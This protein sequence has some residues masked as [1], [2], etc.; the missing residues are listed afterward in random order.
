[1]QFVRK[2]FAAVLILFSVLA[3]SYAEDFY[4]E[5]PEVITTADSRFPRSVTNG[6][7]SCVIWQ[8]TDKKGKQLWLSA[9]YYSDITKPLE[10]SKFTEPVKFSGEVPD[11][12]SAAMK[13]DGSVY[14]ALLSGPHSI[15]IYRISPD[16][17][18]TKYDLPKQSKFLTAPRLYITAKGG[19]R[20]FCSSSE[21]ESFSILTADSDTGTFWSEL[22]QFRPTVRYNNSFVPTLVPYKGG[23][24]VV[25]QAQLLT[26]S[27]ISYQLYGTYSRDGRIWSPPIIL[28]DQKTIPVSDTRV[29]TNYQN[30]SPVLYVSG[31]DCYLSWER[32][33][34]LSENAN[35]W[36]EKITP[37]G[38]VAGSVEQITQAGNA[39]RAQIFNFN[40][41]LSMVWF[42]TRSGSERVYMAQKNGLY[43]DE[44]TLSG[45]RQKS[46]FAFPVISND[47]NQL[48]FV[49]QQSAKSSGSIVMLKPD[50]SVSSPDINPLSFKIG[51][52][53][54]SRNVR[55]RV[56][57]PDDSSGVAGFSYSWSKDPEVRPSKEMEY[58]AG[59][60]TVNLVADQ[61]GDWYF[62]ARVFDYA[63]NISESSYVTY[64]L[65]I[66]APGKPELFLTATDKFGFPTAN[67]FSAQIKKNEEDTDV[68]GYTYSLD[69]IAALPKSL[70]DTPR[71]PLRLSLEQVGSIV[72]SLEEKYAGYLTGSRKV[73]SKIMS[74]KE[75]VNFTSR[76]NGIYILTVAVI[77]EVGNI[78]EKTAKLVVL[79]KFIPKTY[80]LSADSTVNELGEIT[81]D[82]TGGGF[83]Y[84]GNISSIYIDRDGEEPYD[85]ILTRDSGNYKVE[86]DNRITG[87]KLGNNLDEGMYRIGLVH[88]DRGLYMTKQIVKIEQ[89]GTIKIEPEI[90]FVPEWKVIEEKYK[91]TINTNYL[92]LAAIILLSLGILVFAFHGFVSTAR[93]TVLVRKEVAALITG[94]LMPAEKKQKT[95]A[96]KKKGVSLKIKM[97]GFTSALVI[98]IVALVAVPLGYF[99]TNMQER[100]LNRGLQQR[101]D[102][103]LESLSSGAKAYMPAN[104]ILELSYLPGQATSMSEARFATIIG[105]S[106][107]AE[108]A[109]MDYVWATNDPKINEK[110]DTET[111]NF[112]VSRN[113]EEIVQKITKDCID[114]NQKAVEAAGEIALTISELNSE[115]VSLALK[116]DELS[117][118]R[119]EEI[120]V[121]TTEL[122]GK[123][124]TLLNDIS[125]SGASSYPKFDE[126]L[127]DRENT[128]FLFYKP[129]LFRQGSSQNYVHGVILLQVSTQSLVDE[130]DLSRT[131][132]Y[133]IAGIV[134]LLA[135]LVGA[136]LSFILASI[137]IKPIKKLASYV[138]VIGE[139]KDKAKLKGKDFKVTSKDEI[140]QLGEVINNMTSQLAKAAE[141]E[142]LS[143]DGKAVQQAFLPLL[144]GRQ[145]PQTVAEHK[146]DHLECFGYYEGASGVSG[147]YFDYRKLD[148][149]WFAIIKCDASGHGVPAAL[150]MTVVATHFREYFNNWSYAKDGVKLNVLVTKINDALES[151]GLKGK[152]AAMIICLFDTKSG[153]VFMCNAGDN[154]VHIYDSVE[155]KQKILTLSETPAAGP[156]P[157]FMVDMKGGFKVEKTNLKKGDVLFLYTDG[158][159]ESTRLCRRSDFS[160][161]VDELTDQNGNLTNE[162]RKELMEPERVQGVIE[163]VFAKEKFVLNKEDNPVFGE[164]LEFDFTNCEGNL[165]EVILALASVEKVFRLYKT[166]EATVNDTITVDKRI[167]AFLKDHFNLYNYYCSNRVDIEEGNYLEYTNVAEDEQ[168][169]DLTLLAV[170]RL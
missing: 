25:F 110:I 151:L 10:I 42:D 123:L 74:S 12:Y 77:D 161:I 73:P 33:Y 156:L 129:V 116:T 21:N 165:S 163:A 154:I 160:V 124:T 141:D 166:P 119:R 145:R 147:D 51:H 84:D 112:G 89:N 7:E 20:L 28:T 134:A 64:N 133:V 100:T 49:W 15:A 136:V 113:I 102:V 122:N 61:D 150:I 142:K 76:S 78:S 82:V 27:R 32:T 55:I 6:K 53:S 1:M 79:N 90:K 111:V 148:D 95:E 52:H 126:N 66:T 14:V 158:I 96:L 60:N 114:L 143:L 162:E 149:R 54:T 153:D 41:T 11:I 107:N 36:L 108:K 63:G 115:G 101:V 22:S 3:F 121:I 8:E 24:L 2:F 38:V 118:S 125:K 23:D 86:S 144:A 135:V 98:A 59:Q 169:D 81:L 167:D 83:T 65:D 103:M 168:L 35:L 146:D 56:K 40:N 44:T 58:L 85:M 94:G 67:A 9:V 30:Q 132:V 37:E 152:F 104:N 105:E 131:T 71:R 93:E 139:T 137:I 91:Y 106:E 48:S 68:G 26:G 39:S 157:S 31:N 62:H 69:Y 4:W 17:N 138:R 43:W 88:T 99:M 170:K 97:V 5:N 57:M 128:D 19:L 127:L 50:S 16:G 159:E 130:A 92:L 18:V 80:I 140:G 117:V 164:K 45:S 29:Y 34:Y 70:V 72:N 75:V 46:L 13:K 120:A 47:G 155:K 109:G 87:I